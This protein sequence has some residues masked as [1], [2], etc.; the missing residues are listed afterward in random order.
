MTASTALTQPHG[1]A[2]SPQRADSRVWGLGRSPDSLCFGLHIPAASLPPE[3]SA[4]PPQCQR[5]TLSRPNLGGRKW[6]CRYCEPLPLVRGRYQH[7]VTPEGRESR[8]KR[9]A[10]PQRPQGCHAKLIL[11]RRQIIQNQ[12]HHF[13]MQYGMVTTTS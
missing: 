6:A 11:A 1:V 2:G 5:T 3:P 8:G 9:R 4:L 13:T 12:G 7:R 10:L